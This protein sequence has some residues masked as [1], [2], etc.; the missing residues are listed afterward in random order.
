[1]RGQHKE[2]HLMTVE[3]KKLL[4]ENLPYPSGGV[5]QMVYRS[6]IWLYRLGL[7][8]LVGRLFMILTTTGRKSGLPRRTAIEFHQHN[9]RKY[10]M[11]GWRGSDWY[12]NI[13]ANP[14]VTLQT[15]WGTEHA[16]A[17]RL[18][19]I[20]DLEAAWEVAENSPIIRGVLKL[21]GLSWE[22]FVAHQDRFIILTFDPTDEP[23]PPSLEADLRWVLVVALSISLN[24]LLQRWIRARRR[25]KG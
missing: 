24:V 16:R 20:E 17:R 3:T 6:P 14:L 23:T 21:T 10:V 15:A 11:V 19:T 12:K 2:E 13:L 5:M 7:G 1:M 9:G 8:P 25:R 22:S 4:T 18:T